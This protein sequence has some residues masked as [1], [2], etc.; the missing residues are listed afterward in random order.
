MGSNSA[1]LTVEVMDTWMDLN[2]ALCSV[3][4]RDPDLAES[5]DETTMK[6]MDHH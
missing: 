4:P 1:V 6:P 3:S 5:L 2:W